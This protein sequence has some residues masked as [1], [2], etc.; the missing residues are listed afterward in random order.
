MHTSA[1]CIIEVAYKDTFFQLAPEVAGLLTVIGGLKQLQMTVFIEAPQVQH[2]LW[3]LTLVVISACHHIAFNSQFHVNAIG[4]D[5]TLQFYRFLPNHFH[6]FFF[7]VFNRPC[8]LP[9][10]QNDYGHTSSQDDT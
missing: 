10:Y 9:K 4:I 8:L 7:I 3:A 2:L 5:T 1:L 6:R